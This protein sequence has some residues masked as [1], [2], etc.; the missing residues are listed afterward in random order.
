MAKRKEKLIVISGPTASGKTKLSLQLA[1]Q[2]KGA[3]ISADSRA[4][5]QEIDIGTAKP[6]DLLTKAEKKQIKARRKLKNLYPPSHPLIIQGIPHYMIDIIKLNQEFSLAQ[7]QK[8]AFQCIKTAIKNGRLPFLVGGTGLYIK[9]ITSNYQIP[10]VKPNPKLREVLEKTAKKYGSNYLYKI[11]IYYDPETKSF[12]DPSNQRRIIRALEVIFT[13]GQPFSKLRQTKKPNFDILEIYLNPSRQTLYKNIEKR[14][15]KMINLGLV[16]ETK[17]LWEKYPKNPILLTTL[18]YQEI[19][20][21]LKKEIS[22]E[23]A[24]EKIKKNSKNFASRQI[25]WFKKN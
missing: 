1:K 20:L 13:T 12:V 5:Y 21:F 25:T 23:Q 9:S 14:V 15:D 3:I 10:K 17:K 22:K 6:F 18:G 16:E 4:I 7:Y 19:I 8:L 24:I 2:F 11:L